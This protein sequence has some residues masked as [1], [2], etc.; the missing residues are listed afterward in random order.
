MQQNVDVN[1]WGEDIS[2]NPISVQLDISINLFCADL[3]TNS[4][5]NQC[6]I[7]DL[8]NAF[9]PKNKN[10]EDKDIVVVQHAIKIGMFN[11]SGIHFILE[12][13]MVPVSQC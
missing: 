5:K 12:Y 7:V 10:E 8:H 9:K 11:P 6:K 2:D 3:K 13:G 4:D 1:K